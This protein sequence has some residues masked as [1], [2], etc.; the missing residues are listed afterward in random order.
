MW[1]DSG[2][3]GTR[4]NEYVQKVC[5][6]HRHHSTRI[7]AEGVLGTLTDGMNAC[8]GRKGRAVR[9]CIHRCVK[10]GNTLVVVPP[11]SKP[12]VIITMVPSEWI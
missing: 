5:W 2:S 10:R 9:L 11:G 1:L 12:R 3:T 4:A 8:P 7:R 6:E